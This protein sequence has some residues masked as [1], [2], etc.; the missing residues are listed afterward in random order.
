MLSSDVW[1]GT[2]REGGQGGQGGC[3]FRVSRDKSVHLAATITKDFLS[4]YSRV[5]FEGQLEASRTQ[6]SGSQDATTEDLDICI[7]PEIP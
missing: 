7:F 2:G 5:H 3:E 6:I 4:V 1:A